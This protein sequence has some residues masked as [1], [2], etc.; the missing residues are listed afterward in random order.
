LTDALRSVG[1]PAHASPE[2][3]DVA[4]LFGR[5]ERAL[6]MG[7]G[8][9]LAAAAVLALA[10]AT[11]L[12]WDGFVHWPQMRSPFGI[13]DRLL[14]VLMVL[15]ILHTVRSSLQSHELAAEPF[16]VV[17]MIA[18]I[19]RILVVTLETSDKSPESQAV[20]IT[21]LS[22]DHAMIELGILAATIL[23]LS[24]AIYLLR[25]ARMAHHPD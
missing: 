1:E 23:V 12:V 18:A 9:L 17:A 22:F 7:I 15:E 5:F 11:A 6:A 25:R 21:A 10:G 16:L 8:L 19:R 24:I 14:F 3:R 20:A 2:P 13:V 4:R